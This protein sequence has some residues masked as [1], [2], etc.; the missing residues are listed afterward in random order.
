VSF[1]RKGGGQP[2]L[3]SFP[4]SDYACNSTNT[5]WWAGAWPKVAHTRSLITPCFRSSATGRIPTRCFTAGL[6]IQS[7]LLLELELDR[8]NTYLETTF[9]LTLPPRHTVDIHY[10]LRR[11]PDERDRRLQ[12]TIDIHHTLWRVPD[13]RDRML[14]HTVTNTAAQSTWRERERGNL[15]G[16]HSSQIKGLLFIANVC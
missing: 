14:Q 4:Q 8:G 3:P 2:V 15:L 7:A 1:C 12:H 11:V 5:G 16:F 6:C 9:R 13:E 10:T